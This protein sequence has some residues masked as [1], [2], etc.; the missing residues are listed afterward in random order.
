[1]EIFGW[2]PLALC[3]SDADNAG[4]VGEG[5]VERVVRANMNTRGRRCRG[6]LSCGRIYH[7][8]LC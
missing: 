1:M 6:K 3:P 5:E 7:V 4:D 2:L 8:Y